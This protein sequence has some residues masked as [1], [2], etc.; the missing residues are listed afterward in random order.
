MI[1]TTKGLGR[2]RHGVAGQPVKPL[3]R[4][5]PPYK[6]AMVTMRDVIPRRRQR[7][8]RRTVAPRTAASWGPRELHAVLPGGSWKGH[9]CFVVGGGPSLREFDWS[10]L[11]GE[12]VIGVNRAFEECDPAI[13]FSM[14]T[15]LWSWVEKGKFGEVLQ[16]RFVEYPGLKVWLDTAHAPFPEDILTV[17]CIGY[18]QLSRDLAGGLGSGGNSGYGA[19][20]LALCLGAD[21]IYLLGFDMKGEKGKQAWFHSGYPIVQKENV[22][23]KFR[24]T[25]EQ[26]ADEI[27]KWAKV[28]NLSSNSDLR[29]FPFGKIEDVEPADHPVVI[30]YYTKDTGYAVEVKRLRRS[31]YVHGLEHDVVGV[32]SLGSWQ[33]N[34]HYKAAFIRNML[35]KYPSRALLFLDADA[36]VCKYPELF[37]GMTDIDIAV[38][39]RHGKELLSGT[40]Y[41]RNTEA[42]R[43]LVD[44]WIALN[45]A[46]PSVWE[47]KNLATV[48]EKMDGIRVHRLPPE[49]CC[50]F[51]TMIKE[52]GDP[53]IEH[54][55]A[56][57]R[58]KKGAGKA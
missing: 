36:A 22:Y 20:N 54:Y 9:R 26:Y 6:S 46:N 7:P 5:P 57:R 13:I 35:K 25:F 38:H 12:L 34:T 1:L 30:S 44:N 55:Q 14:D 40:L 42:T 51:D 47:Q 2:R 11:K 23:R 52:S 53:V 21:P 27:N 39:F 58:L 3:R 48:L 33:A 19:L 31:L 29:C 32:D 15:R 28:I 17:K 16:K 49:Y 18:H 41:F 56:S 45:D 4:K 24:S 8:R 37:V 50:I 43:T 10:R